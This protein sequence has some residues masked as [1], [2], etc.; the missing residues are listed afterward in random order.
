MTG[1]L[2]LL[3]TF[4]PT[5]PPTRV[6]VDDV[7][8]EALKAWEVPGAAVVIVSPDKCLHLQGYGLRQTD[9]KQ[10]VTP[11]TIFPLASC[12]KAFT[13]TLVASLVD[14]GKLKWDDPVRRHLPDFHLSDPAADALVTLRDLAAHRTGVASHDLLWYRAPWSQTEMVRRVGKLPLSCPFRTDM[15]YQSIMYIALGQAAAAAGG[16]PWKDLVDERIRVPLGMRS[17]SY[18]SAEAL[19]ATDHSSGHHLDKEGKLTPVEW[20]EQKEPNPAGSVNA[21]ARDLALWLQ[22]HL[23][24]GKHGDDQLISEA[25]LSETHSPQTIIRLEGGARA[26]NPD[27]IQ[28]SYGLGW[29]VQDYRG[30]LVVQ[31]AG[32]IDGF[33]VHLTILPKDGYAFA[34]LANREATRMNL[35]LS[36]TLVD[37]LLKLPKRDWNKYLGDVLKEEEEEAKIRNRQREL[38]QPPNSVP[39]VSLEK[40]A[41]EFEEAAYGPATIRAGKDGLVWEWGTWKLPLVHYA[42]DTF[43]LKSD[44]SRLN[45]ASLTFQVA[46]GTV[47]AFKLFGLS[48]RKK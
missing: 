9:T 14:D 39:T 18:T 20:Y 25:S 37:L 28:L 41:G 30:H 4:S 15:Q 45:G 47:G 42:F 3:L 27:T 26:I 12:S 24:G 6:P 43:R 19:K 11:D 16:K 10:P 17:M 29:V 2:L 40:F 46:G 1:T 33:R 38:S 22:F 5:A 23:N 34:I 35:A 7:V 32:L 21:S 48:F 44:D 36:N 13:T 8:L 31:H